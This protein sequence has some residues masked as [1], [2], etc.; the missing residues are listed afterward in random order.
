MMIR[1]LRRRSPREER[2]AAAGT[3]GPIRW[4]R[5]RRTVVLV[6]FSS[7]LGAGRTDSVN[8]GRIIPDIRVRG[9]RVVLSDD[10]RAAVAGQVDGFR[11]VGGRSPVEEVLLERTVAAILIYEV[12]RALD[13]SPRAAEVGLPGLDVEGALLSKSV[14]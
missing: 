11:L 1:C 7:T 6:I 10:V 8:S 9:V 14:T 3:H 13:L 12:A 4:G 2:Q 5:E